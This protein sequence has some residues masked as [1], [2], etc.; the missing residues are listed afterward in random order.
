MRR[1]KKLSNATKY[2]KFP[3]FSSLSTAAAQYY[4]KSIQNNIPKY[5]QSSLS[6]KN[7]NDMIY[8]S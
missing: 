3:S 7:I 4:N 5:L 2:S 1:T 8:L 6:N